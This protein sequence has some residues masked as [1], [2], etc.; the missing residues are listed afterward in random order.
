M[1]ALVSWDNGA[2]RA[3]LYKP[4]VH[5][6]TLK[7]NN[8]FGSVTKG[9]TKFQVFAQIDS[10]KTDISAFKVTIANPYGEETLID[11]RDSS[12]KDFP[13]KGDFWFKTKEISYDFSI[14]GQYMIRFY[15]TLDGDSA[16]VSE[17]AISSVTA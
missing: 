13:T 9:R 14:V 7:D 12:D 5:M 3:S 6:F 15:M 1:Q 17:K 2:K 11:G 10:L 4:N 16:I 8:P